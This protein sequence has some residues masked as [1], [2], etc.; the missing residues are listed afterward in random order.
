[1]EKSAAKD[2]LTRFKGEIGMNQN[3]EFL[4][5][6][7]Q[8]AQMGITTIEQLI[9]KVEDPSFSKELKSQLN[10]YTNIHREAADQLHKNGQSEKEIPKMAEVGSA[11]SIGMKTLTDH[12]PSHISEMM[13]KGSMMGIID[14]T[15][16]LQKY[17]N[18]SNE[19]KGLA[20][21]LLKTEQHNVEQLKRYLS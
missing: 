20:N 19:T 13:L 17:D 9:P 8:N 16:N 2:Y 15:K 5:Y 6:I 21:K 11:M 14:V 10:E 12:S 4:N 18:A 7:Y 3:T 1:M